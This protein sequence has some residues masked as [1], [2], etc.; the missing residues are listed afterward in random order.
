MKP[1]EQQLCWELFIPE[2]DDDDT[3][4]FCH[5]Y[6]EEE[7]KEKTKTTR[8]CGTMQQFMDRLAA[9]VIRAV[10]VDIQLSTMVYIDYKLTAFDLTISSNI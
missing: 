9:K 1:R 4:E 5:G 10:D 8:C 3:T 2:N 6:L 7:I